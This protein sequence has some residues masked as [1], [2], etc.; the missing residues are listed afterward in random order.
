MHTQKLKSQTIST[1]QTLDFP[2]KHSFGLVLSIMRHLSLLFG[3][4]LPLNLLPHLSPTGTII[5]PTSRLISREYL[6]PTVKKLKLEFLKS[7]NN[8]LL[9]SVI[10]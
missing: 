2:V 7:V 5:A 4:Q 9:E 8:T 3:M 6:K 1:E 10:C